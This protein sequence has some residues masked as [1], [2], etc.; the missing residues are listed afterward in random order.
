MPD[1]ASQPESPQQS[2]ESSVL[3][4]PRARFGRFGAFVLRHLNL[5]GLLTV[6]IV[7][8]AADFALA[9]ASDQVF[10]A[11]VL[12]A[13]QIVLAF[14]WVHTVMSLDRWEARLAGVEKER[15]WRSWRAVAYAIL[16]GA[17]GAALVAKTV[18]VHDALGGPWGLPTDAYRHY[19]SFV[20]AIFL[21]GLLGRG[22]RMG[23]F[24]A[25]VADHPA[26]LMALTFG[27]VAVLGGFLLTLPI[28]LQ[29]IGD[30]SFVDGL[31]TSMSA[32]CVT[33]L[34]VNDICATYTFFG[35][36]VLVGLMQIGGLGIMVLSSAVVILAGRRLRARG[37]VVLAEMIDSDSVAALRR[38]LKTIT[39][40]TLCIEAVGAIV[41]YIAFSNVPEIA[42]GPESPHPAAGAGSVLWSAIFH[43]VSAFCNAGFSLSH[44][45]LIHFTGSWWVSGTIAAL[46][47]VG[48]IGFPV[49]EELAVRIRDQ[50][51]GIVPPKLSLHTRIVLLASAFLVLVGTLAFLF[52]ERD[53]VLAER[54]AH[55]RILSALFQSVTTRTAGFNT[56]D[57]SVMG[58]PIILLTCFL[59]F[60]GAS[61]GST[62]GGIKTT[63][64]AVL[65][66]AFRAEVKSSPVVRLL[67]RAIPAPT[68]RKA[69]GV[70]VVSITFVAAI[71]FILL[72]T[73]ADLLRTRYEGDALGPLRILFET[74]SA[75]ATCGLST[76]ITQHLSVAGKLVITF[77]MFVGR[78]GPLTLALAASS[79]PKQ[80]GF[81][82]PEERVLIG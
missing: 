36:V 39:I 53:G 72:I 46:V 15:G 20:L 75:F 71:S 68:V 10:W 9:S 77:T 48:G 45:N 74:V 59:M 54:P 49:L 11:A 4:R 24:L 57:F 34:A 82:P 3:R 29:R 47:T 13:L 33:G 12:T 37:S 70:A 6:G 64:F 73:E 16:F 14:P 67:D 55:E 30:A 63:T 38:T 60:V 21:L 23:R 78:I 81:T 25:S 42:L 32:V 5:T 22:S 44:G 35:Q 76:G 58:S 27:V 40:A 31:F 18:T 65:F 56:L 26:R 79:K 17:M 2:P 62:G 7:V 50:R 80:E 41:L 28:S 19:A 69:L 1:E 51:R 8:G 52:L 61:P 43:S 66:S